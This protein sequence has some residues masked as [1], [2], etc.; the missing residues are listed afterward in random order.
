MYF[1]S[2][3][4]G[5]SAVAI[6]DTR[7]PKGAG[8]IYPSLADFISTGG[9]VV[10][11]RFQFFVWTILGGIAF[12]VAVLS[13]DPATISKLPDI[14][15][16]FWKLMGISS[17]GYLAGKLVRKP[18]PIVDSVAVDK[19]SIVP[20]SMT[21]TGRKLSP[22]ATFKIAWKQSDTAYQVDDVKPEHGAVE[23]TP[24]SPE[25]DD[26]NTPPEFYKSVKLTIAKPNPGWLISG[27]RITIINPDGQSADCDY[28]LTVTQP[29][30]C[31]VVATKKDPNL[32]LTIR[33]Q[34]L[35][36]AISA[37]KINDS[38]L[39]P[40]PTPA[41][42]RDADGGNTLTMNVP[43]TVV[44]AGAA[45]TMN[46]LITFAAGPHDTNKMEFTIA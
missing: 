20:L 34:N 40:V 29:V 6:T 41:S 10:T 4:T 19:A 8:P 39:A 15:S 13:I 45:A 26:S 12:L 16:D 14:P 35:T 17:G 5:V 3:V 2:A 9:V 18:G 44:P 11:E 31:S 36:G 24:P 22:K 43:V 25:A 23:T 37:V 28:S 7:G 46:I 32:E 1:I 42:I 38:P 27:S 21:L 33:G 30:I